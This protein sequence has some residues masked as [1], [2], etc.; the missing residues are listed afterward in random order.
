MENVIRRGVRE[1]MKWVTQMLLVVAVSIMV[2]LHCMKDEVK[3]VEK[4]ELV[5]IDIMH[6]V[7]PSEESVHDIARKYIDMHK[8][9]NDYAR[10]VFAIKHVNGLLDNPRALRTGDRIIIPLL[11]HK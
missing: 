4:P 3:Q 7:N 1:K 11:V 10:F 8:G 6:V 9:P 2:M 5:R